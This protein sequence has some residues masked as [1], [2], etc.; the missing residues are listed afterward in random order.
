[1][2]MTIDAAQLEQLAADPGVV[3]IEPDSEPQLH[4]ERQG[5]LLA[6]GDLGPGPGAGYLAAYDALLF[7]PSETPSTLP[8]IVD[9]ADSAI[10]NGTTTPTSADLR[11][12]GSPER[13]EPDRLRPQAELRGERPGRLPGL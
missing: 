9:L 3:A 5:L 10:G 13:V 11:V 7:T 8:F 4:D 6:D 1:M 12:D 2:R